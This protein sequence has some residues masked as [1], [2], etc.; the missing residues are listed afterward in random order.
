[1]KTLV[2]TLLAIVSATAPVRAQDCSGWSPIGDPA[3][4]SAA[5]MVFDS[6]RNTVVMFGGNTGNLNSNT[7]AFSSE[8]WEFD[9][10]TWTFRTLEGPFRA[11]GVKMAYDAARERT[12]VTG[13]TLVNMIGGPSHLRDTWEW[14]GSAWSNR[15]LCPVTI[16]SSHA[17]DYMPGVGVVAFVPNF[18]LNAT[19]VYT[20]D[21]AAWA[22]HHQQLPYLTGALSCTYDPTRAALVLQTSA[23]TYTWDGSNFAQIV[24]TVSPSPHSIRYLP[25][26]SKV[27]G[28]HSSGTAI[29]EL[30]A[31]GWT[32][33][34]ANTGMNLPPPIASAPQAD[35]SLLVFGG[36]ATTNSRVNCWRFDGTTITP[37]ERRGP[38]GTEGPAMAY[39]P[40]RRVSVAF[41][42]RHGSQTLDTTTWELRGETWT[43]RATSGPPGRFDG[44]MAFN[45]ATNSCFLQGGNSTGATWS[46]NGQA[47]TSLG[48][49]GPTGDGTMTW[50]SGDNQ[51][52]YHNNAG[53]PYT[54]D[55]AAW[56]AHVPY[57]GTIGSN[58]SFA[59]DAARAQFIAVALNNNGTYRWTGANW[60][61]FI[62]PT[63][64]STYQ[65]N[66]VY[67]ARLGG[68]LLFGGFV[69]FNNDGNYPNRTY[70]L[71]ST[72]NSWVDLNVRGP[73]GR[74][75]SGFVDDTTAERI[76]M[77]SG[78][79]GGHIPRD[80]W[81]YASGPA[82][83]AVQPQR[84]AAPQGSSAE[85]YIIAKGGGVIS[86]QWRR[87][88]QPLA[89][90]ARFSGARS[91]TLIISNVNNADAG[92]YDAVISNPCGSD[93]SATATL[94]VT[95][96]SDFDGDGDINTDQDIEA[97]FACLAGDCCPTCGSA[98]Y[99]GDGD[100]GT[101]GDIE[102]FF[103]VLAGNSC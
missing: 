53:Q 51:L 63:Q 55:G 91:D 71:G 26:R 82:A 40:V 12:V 59:Y 73:F 66:M 23:G 16:L 74:K 38:I 57:S 95:C 86:Y 61:R 87:N 98:D 56:V 41:G 92:E 49:T 3:P 24:A 29:V 101:D 47:W 103:R 52:V 72:A 13:G 99:D 32:Q 19:E 43:Q 76:V 79:A 30:N 90:D 70:F 2:T 69:G 27:I 42:G 75:Y 28:F 33:I 80:T 9:G 6:S 102:S 37:I 18:S 96:Q 68:S 65:P 31:P 84:T 5:S 94:A 21:G 58:A 34:A 83:V 4:R 17:M 45:P 97:F 77:Y 60:S 39:D 8:T 48:G 46:W 20:W 11:S 1:M 7:G 89:D 10:R 81:K 25:A 54:W 14:D 50:N 62:N 15:G 67:S 36:A 85:L 22:L 78:L 35:G 93:T 88:G 64:T 100:T 44:S